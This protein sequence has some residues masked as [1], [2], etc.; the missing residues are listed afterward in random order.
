M[1]RLFGSVAVALFTIA[2]AHAEGQT[3]AVQLEVDATHATER[4]V[5]THERMAV[6][7]GPLTLSYPE[8]YPGEH[9]P[10]GRVGNIGGLFFRADG[11]T[12][13]WRRDLT[14]AYAFHL[15][16]PAGVR[17]L[18]VEFD[19]LLPEGV[20]S[21]R[22]MLLRWDQLLL[23]KADTPVSTIPFAAHLKLPAGW[24]F[25]SA[26]RGEKSADGI[27]F[28]QASLETIMDSP[29]LA[30]QYLRKLPL[31]TVSG[32]Q[33]EL[34]VAAEN[35][36][37]L[38]DA[39]YAAKVSAAITQADHILGPG[40]FRDYHF[41]VHASEYTSGGGIEHHESSDD[42]LAPNFFHDPGPQRLA[43]Y[44]LPHE[45]AHSWNGK[46]RRPADLYTSTYQQPM[47]TDL[48]WV[49]EGATDFLGNLLA[50]RSGM[51]SHEEAM[52][53]F[54]THAA[55]LTHITGREW[56]PLQDTTDDAWHTMLDVLSG[57]STWPS[58]LR[59]ID[60]YEEGNFIW[61][62]ADA[63]V[64]QQTHGKKSL[65]DFFRS[66]YGGPAGKPQ[67][68]TYTAEDVFEALNAVA[69]YDWKGL[70]ENHLQ[71]TGSEAPLGGLEKTG[72][73]LVYTSNPNAFEPPPGD[74]RMLGLDTIGL[75]A[76]G[77]GEIS[78]VVMGDLA[79]KAGFFVGMTVETVN[80]GKWSGAA[81][82]A[83]LAAKQPLHFTA[84]FAGVTRTMDVPYTG[85]LRY[86]HLERIGGKEDLLTGILAAR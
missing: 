45:Y 33:H 4:L 17:E 54:A 25:A 66:F 71:N 11:K 20:A 5:H 70:F 9:A 64:L 63:I 15:V 14:D 57:Q 53:F 50:A 85:G 61:L 32:Q 76:N 82:R 2:V 36:T 69:P 65:D 27:A 43:A 19:Y 46:F 40:H 13:P 62:E 37:D 3:S 26:L 44:L 18:D 67:V 49:Y 8:W 86:P 28:E 59:R 10:T 84:N 51:W 35:E 31:V 21:A 78:D 55:N 39:D 79:A 47:K 12:I 75:A 56:R 60:Y 72:W 24:Q 22:V 73:K 74:L 42:Q 16:I 29:V 68:K 41:L 48:L 80:G 7:P 83:A 52:D 23:Y 38:P 34:D 30:G 6:Q 81:F 1:P 58:Y 77:H